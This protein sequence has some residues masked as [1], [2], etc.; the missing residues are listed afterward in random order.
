MS[1]P[2]S[3]ASPFVWDDPF[4]IEDQLTEDERMLRDAARAEVDVKDPLA[5]LAGLHRCSSGA[6]P[7]TDGVPITFC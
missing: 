7:T 5:E 4:L 2:A 6:P 1:T 3:A